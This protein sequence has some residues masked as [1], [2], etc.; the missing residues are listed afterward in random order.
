MLNGI[1][2]DFEHLSSA[3]NDEDMFEVFIRLIRVALK[4]FSKQHSSVCV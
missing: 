2:N 3:E 4:L 1:L